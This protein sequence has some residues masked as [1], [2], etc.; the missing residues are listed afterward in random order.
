MI[1]CYWQPS[2]LAQSKGSHEGIG[3]G[4]WSNTVD[5]WS[6]HAAYHPVGL[7]AQKCVLSVSSLSEQ[8][9]EHPDIRP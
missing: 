5:D 3:T 7:Q 9:S 4:G 8:D 2:Y 6:L 1:T